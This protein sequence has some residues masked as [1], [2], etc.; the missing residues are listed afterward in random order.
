MKR[1][2]V[3]FLLV[4]STLSKADEG[5][6]LPLLLE[7]MNEKEMKSLC[8]K[9]SG[10]DIYNI[11]TGSLKDAIV[12]FGGFCTAEVISEQ[13]LLLTNHHCGYSAIQNHSTL[14]RNYLDAGFWAMSKKRRT[15]K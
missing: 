2:L 9:I 5:M 10:K 14:Q 6:W 3:V 8:M 13:G 12:S 1:L 7:K 11:N 4:I 15:A